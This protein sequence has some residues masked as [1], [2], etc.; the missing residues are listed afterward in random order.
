MRPPHSN[1]LFKCFPPLPLDVFV[2]G[3][4]D[5]M[6]HLAQFFAKKQNRACKSNSFFPFLWCGLE[7]SPPLL[8]TLNGLWA[9]SRM[10]ANADDCGAFCRITGKTEV[11][12][13][14]RLHY[15]F[16]QRKSQVALTRDRTWTSAGTSRCLTAWDKAWSSASLTIRSIGQGLCPQRPFQSRKL[17]QLSLVVPS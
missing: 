12:E 14:N 3:R 10:M 1:K 15:R 7:Q 6:F 9:Q 11:L 2:V 8:R 4:E 17:M 13:E 5:L 16:T